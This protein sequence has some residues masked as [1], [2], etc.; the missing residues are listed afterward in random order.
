MKLSHRSAAGCFAL[1]SAA[2]LLTGN[3]SW[4]ATARV[5][6]ATVQTACAVSGS[7]AYWTSTTSDDAKFADNDAIVNLAASL[8]YSPVKIYEWVYD[9][10]EFDAS[11]GSFQGAQTV[12][13]SRTGNSTDQASLLL[14]LLRASG[15]PARYAEGTARMDLFNDPRLWYWVK[16]EGANPAFKT[17][18]GA[19]PVTAAALAPSRNP[20]AAQ[21]GDFLNFPMTWVEACVPYENYRGGASDTRGYQWVPMVP[22]FK[23][24][25]PYGEQLA[26]GQTYDEMA[27]SVGQGL[28][29]S[30]AS[31]SP[32]A[33]FG[34]KLQVWLNGQ[35]AHSGKTVDDVLRKWERLPLTTE[36]LPMALPFGLKAGAAVNRYATLPDTLKMNLRLNVLAPDASGNP[37]VTYAWTGPAATVGSKRL[38]LT[39][40]GTTAA[41]QTTI[42]GYR[43]NQSIAAGC[44]AVVL[45]PVLR[46]DGVVQTWSTN[47][48][49]SQ[50]MCRTVGSTATLNTFALKYEMFRG[51]DAA[52]KCQAGDTTGSC[53]QSIK[54]DSANLLDQRVLIAYTGQASDALIEK[55]RQQLLTE[56]RARPSN[57]YALA[58]I[59][60][61]QG[62]LLNITGLRYSQRV[63]TG[64]RRAG[65][66]FGTR[67]MGGVLMGQ[68]SVS[69]KPVYVAGV[70]F[71][72][73]GRRLFVDFPGGQF[74]S[75]GDLVTGNR[76]VNQMDFR[77]AGIELSALE[78]EVPG[79]VAFRDA[80]STARGL[81]AA[82][83]QNVPVSTIASAADVDNAALITKE[84]AVNGYD[85]GTI[86][87]L[88]SLFSGLPAGWSATALV[89]KTRTQYGEWQG[90]VALALYRD[91]TEVRSASYLIRQTN[92]NALNGGYQ[93]SPVLTN[94]YTFNQSLLPTTAPCLTCGYAAASPIIAATSSPTQTVTFGPAAQQIFQQAAQPALYQNLTSNF[95]TTV[96]DPVD[97]VTGGLDEKFQDLRIKGTGG[98]DFVLSRSYH[99]LPLS[100]LGPMGWGWSH[101][102]HSYLVFMSQ[103]FPNGAC[104]ATG[105]ANETDTTTRS[106]LWVDNGRATRI[107]VTGTVAGGGVP[108]TAAFVPPKNVQVSVT[109]SGNTYIVKDLRTG[110][111]LTY[112]DGSA[113]GVSFNGKPNEAAMLTR[114]E[115][116][117][118]NYLNLSYHAGTMDLAAVTDRA[119]RALTFTLNSNKLV[120]KIADWTGREW[121]YTYGGPD[122]KQLLSFKSPHRVEHNLS[123]NASYT[124]YAA[125][126]GGAR[127]NLLKTITT[128]GGSSMLFSY[129]HNGQAYKQTDGVGQTLTFLYTPVFRQ[130]RVVDQVGRTTLYTFNKDAAII[131]KVEPDGV[132]SRYEYSATNP[133]NRTRVID[134]AGVGTAY[135]F[136][137]SANAGNNLTRV[138]R[139]DGKYRSFSEFTT[140]T[141]AAGVC[142]L[143]GKTRDENQRYVLKKYDANGR[144]TDVIAL[145]DSVNDANIATVAPTAATFDPTVVSNGAYVLRLEKI[146]YDAYGNVATRTTVTDLP[147][148]TGPTVTYVYANT[149]LNLSRIERQ[150]AR[151]FGQ[152][153]LEVS[154]TM[155]YDALGRAVTALD[156]NWISVERRYDLDDR[157]VAS[158][159]GNR[160]WTEY[161]F[162]ADGRALGASVADAGTVLSFGNSE[163]DAVGR[164]EA[165]YDALGRKTSTIYGEDGLIEQVVD[166]EGRTVR[167]RYDVGQRESA[168]TDPTGRTAV[169]RFDAQGRPVL[170]IDPN[171]NQVA[172]SYN[173]DAALGQLKAMVVTPGGGVGVQR[174]TQVSYDALARPS[175]VTDT[176]GNT[177]LTTYD[178]YGRK[179]RVVGPVFLDATSNANR[180]PVTRYRYDDRGRLADIS[181]GYT[182]ATTDAAAALDTSDVLTIQ[183]S[184]YHNDLDQ[185]TSVADGTGATLVT[186]TYDKYNHLL[187]KTDALGNVTTNTYDPSTGDL[188]TAS[189]VRAGQTTRLLTYTYDKLGRVRTESI[190][191]GAAAAQ[192]LTY[193]YN[194]LGQ[195]A[196]ITDNRGAKVYSYFYTAAGA[197]DR[198]LDPEGGVTRFVYDANKRLVS[199][200]APGNES[201]NFVYDAAGRLIERRAG[202][203]LITY[204]YN[205]DGS[206]ATVRHHGAAGLAAPL[207]TYSYAYNANGLMSQAV[208]GGSALTARTRNYTYDAMARLL[209][210]N[211]GTKTIETYGYDSQGNRALYTDGSLASPISYYYNYTVNQQNR[212]A[213][214]RTGG[215]AAATYFRTFEYDANGNILR[216]CSVNPCAAS[217]PAASQLYQ[218]SYDVHGN[219][220]TLTTPAATASFG[221]D[222][223]GRRTQRVVGAVVENFLYSGGMFM[224][225]YGSSWATRAAQTVFA[226]VDAPVLRRTGSTPSYPAADQLGS[227]T[228][229]VDAAGYSVANGAY[230]S[231]GKAVP[232]TANV[233]RFGYAGREPEGSSLGGLMY[234]RSRY[235]DPELGR[236]TRLDPTGMAD[237]VNQYSYV[238]NSPLRYVDPFG[239][240]SRS[241]QALYSARPETYGGGSSLL[242]S[243]MGYVNSFNNAMTSVGPAIGN[244][245]NT[246]AGIDIGM[247]RAY[248]AQA[249]ALQAEM[250]PNYR[251]ISPT[252]A[253]IY[254]I[255]PA[256]IA[257]PKLD[258]AL[259]IPSQGAFDTGVRRTLSTGM[260]LTDA[261]LNP[262][263]VG[264]FVGASWATQAAGTWID[265]ASIAQAA[266]TDFNNFVTGNSMVPTNTIS[267]VSD[268][269]I[270]RVGALYGAQAGAAVGLFFG[271]TVGAVVGGAVGGLVGGIGGPVAVDKMID[272]GRNFGRPDYSVPSSYDM[273]G[274]S[275]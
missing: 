67:T 253:R 86:T 76:P 56:V 239:T 78:S 190:K 48:G 24:N 205:W 79:E 192:T 171:G 249:S 34:R 74:L 123:A 164:V 247:D 118:G 126:D 60:A 111:E 212:L 234:Y 216:K 228:N 270:G 269:A 10:V 156:D 47:P 1:V 162:D 223:Q 158:R 172:R 112:T 23:L 19:Y 233:G 252:A 262:L 59:D 120:T 55:R 201:I 257:S 40:E 132:E 41:H 53:A 80:V 214:I 94:N 222:S 218:M 134:G 103:S 6:S 71:A 82:D 177:S 185:I 217:T 18:V 265:R 229:V 129:Y 151:N 77:L 52:A 174:T 221:Y 127:A 150:I 66:L 152:G 37:T 208:E 11:W 143:P 122:G 139:A 182:S 184:Y 170:T 219:V 196:A 9:E 250:A 91:A 69:Y 96:G 102:Y 176:A 46:L 186:N 244:I 105:C 255:L 204:T 145:K 179:Y 161:S 271:G 194:T 115:D 26:H 138:T 207:A 157:V 188:L 100:Q 213:D 231:F 106:L 135:A 238:K 180:R 133:A 130:T 168:V 61:T 90:L 248:G 264:G 159:T 149:G 81:K 146:T 22:A 148:G 141:A 237:G 274:L 33:E 203:L 165:T 142:G 242:N 68:V 206:I 104:P 72:V 4:A 63:E 28:V 215:F 14:A 195:L 178:G 160:A 93:A 85:A 35:A 193:D 137:G 153:E 198:V 191:V 44:T 43:S 64:N 75:A 25:R 57:S 121:Q 119:A 226:G 117:S 263:A 140:C 211:D 266:H 42:D 12:L 268:I 21:D 273:F 251:A 202:K 70:P 2:V 260:G 209:T 95:Y 254:D 210:V 32:I 17:F 49:A 50:A 163:F 97:V 225:E 199:L 30:S 92:G 128:S 167:F 5:P 98:L 54:I 109:R 131:R 235:Y 7:P 89:P 31:G 175:K 166:P 154:A 45:K 88:K 147:S 241:P 36:V 116:R 183:Q 189:T 13:Q 51:P 275:P 83:D 27:D 62:E 256:K 187:T 181:Q 107:S 173:G 227:V 124:Y 200:T 38:A 230:E 272:G 99:S 197:I 258:Y 16:V 245:G 240:S 155:K 267:T 65:A 136:D 125:A 236:F 144:A 58:D 113:G 3:T 8:N 224:D 114:I 84:P 110:M 73:E 101:S 39:W 232:R 29:N 259:G 20:G 220:A 261:G 243:A 87:Y 15:Y 246:L 108:A 169:T